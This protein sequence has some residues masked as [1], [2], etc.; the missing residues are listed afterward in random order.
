[1]TD[2]EALQAAALAAPAD[3]TARLMLADYLDETGES[4]LARFLRAGVVA[5]RYRT[6]EVI[7]D[8][9][10][11]SALA[12][13]P[14]VASS[15]APVGW[16]A[17]LGLGPSPLVARDWAWDNVADLVTVSDS[18]GRAVAAWLVERVTVTDV[19]GLSF[20]IDPPGDDNPG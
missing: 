19:R 2:R 10:F 15:D 5:S 12:D 1:V 9:E 14:A 6:A 3:D 11:Y 13:L 16:L 7:E 4:D 17:A 18:A 20:W 8:A